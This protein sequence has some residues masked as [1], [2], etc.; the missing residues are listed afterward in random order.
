M[1]V[2]LPS[3]AVGGRSEVLEAFRDGG[4]TK[5]A[6][7]G[8]RLEVTLVTLFDD[9]ARQ[10]V[11]FSCEHWNQKLDVGVEDGDGDGELR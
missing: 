3:E 7:A 5:S 6:G 8:R 11:L 1:R 2:G 10:P 9:I 4:P